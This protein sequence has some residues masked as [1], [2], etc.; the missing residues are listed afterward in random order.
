M[1]SLMIVTDIVSM[2]TETAPTNRGFQMNLFMNLI[3]AERMI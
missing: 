3:T 1:K 2:A